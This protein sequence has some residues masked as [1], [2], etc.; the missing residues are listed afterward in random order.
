M[1]SD[2]TRLP[3]PP[4]KH[5]KRVVAQQGRT[6]IEADS[7]EQADILLRLG[8]ATAADVIGPCGAPRLPPDAPDANFLIRPVDGE[9][10]DFEIAPGHIY[11]DGILCQNEDAVRAT[12]Q[13]GLPADAP[14]AYDGENWHPLPAPTGTYAAYLVTWELH[15]TG[16]DDPDIL[17]PALN[18]VDTATRTQTLWQVRLLRIG[19]AE[20]AELDC[21]SGGEVLEPF[22]D[23]SAATLRAYTAPEEGPSEGPCLPVTA[24]GGYSRLEN[25]TYRV[26]VHDGGAPGTATFKWDRDNG[27][28]VARLLDIEDDGLKVSSLGRDEALGFAPDQWVEITD[29]RRELLR[30]PGTLVKVVR[31]EVLDNGD[32]VLVVDAGTATDTLDPEEFD[33]DASAKVRRWSMANATEVPTVTDGIPKDLENRVQIEHVGAGPY[34]TGD[35]WIIPARTLTGEILWPKGSDGLPLAV[36]PHGVQYHFCRLALLRIGDDGAITEVEDCRPLFPPLT[37][38]TAGDVGYDDTACR[39]GAGT[40]QEA[41]DHLCERD[42]PPPETDWPTIEKISWDND[43][44]LSLDQLLGDGLV[45]TF[46]RAM[47]P[48]SLSLDTVIVTLEIPHESGAGHVPLILHGEVK[49]QNETELVFRPDRP[50]ELEEVLPAWLDRE[51]DFE[52]EGLLCRVVLKGNAIF[53]EDGRHLDG[54]AFG[55][56]A[57]DAIALRL[58]SGDGTE[59]GDFESWFYLVERQ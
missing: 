43:T 33:T 52:S 42:G 51:A 19:E 28:V 29:D 17:E 8:E 39:L 34:F 57:D 4:Y 41:I 44:E 45:I 31:P 36:P 16:L 5:F 18:G 54:E 48:A 2:I 13:P 49:P 10:T 55:G 32:K 9:A 6:Q 22:E 37:D 1:K 58:P 20:D 21:D 56:R 14:I 59:G 38:I 27:T 25:Q 3:S 35:F 11:V 15:R 47:D 7:N 24:G 12:A 30:I 40:V 46:S 23:R 26:E 53:D 50:N